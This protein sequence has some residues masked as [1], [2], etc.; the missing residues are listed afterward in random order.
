MSGIEPIY[1]PLGLRIQAARK[2]HQPRMSQEDVAEQ[3][4][5][6]RSA[7]SAIE[8]GRQ[9]LLVHTLIKLCEVLDVTPDDLLSD[10][11]TYDDDNVQS[12]ASVNDV[13]LSIVEKVYNKA[14]AS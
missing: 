8:G 5:L 3:V 10:L 6:P 9:R 2:Q 12:D 4:G 11:S 1:R 14:A 7:I 13:D